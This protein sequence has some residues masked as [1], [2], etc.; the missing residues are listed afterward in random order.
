[1]HLDSYVEQVQD[2]LIATAAL[3]DERAREIASALTTAAA[4]AMRLALL[5]AVAAA[6]E[7]ITAELVDRPGAPAVG[8]QLQSDEIRVVVSAPPPA[9]GANAP[10]AGEASARISLRLSETLK[11]E[12]DSAAAQAGVSVNTWL[13]RAA[14]SALGQAPGESNATGRPGRPNAQRVT[15]WI[16]S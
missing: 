6:A 14:A 3:G 7:E 8:V 4:P 1:M 9:P 5:G 12:V 16:T 15:G 2:Q 11:L 13:V 10:D